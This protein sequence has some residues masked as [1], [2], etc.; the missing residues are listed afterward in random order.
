MQHQLGDR[1]RDQPIGAATDHHDD[2]G[3]H[4]SRSL[5]DRRARGGV[6]DRSPDHVNALRPKV[7]RHI[8]EILRGLVDRRHV[9]GRETD[10]WQGRRVNG[11]YC[12]ASSTAF[13]S[14]ASDARDPSSGT[15]IFI[16]LTLSPN[17]PRIVIGHSSSIHLDAPG[18]ATRALHLRIIGLFPPA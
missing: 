14:A 2:I 10:A 1:A 12:L 3:F 16:T 11:A 6:P 8:A 17:S 15:R 5:H 13:G 9:S 7:R 4:R 18:V